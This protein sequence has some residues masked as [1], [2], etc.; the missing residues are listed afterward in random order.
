L[1]VIRLAVIRLAFPDPAQREQTA[2]AAG[3]EPAR[4][5]AAGI[6][7]ATANPGWSRTQR[8]KTGQDGVSRRIRDGAVHPVA[9][10]R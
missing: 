4:S 3:A 9:D 7:R 10:N 5:S 8:A 6:R 2:M 1:V